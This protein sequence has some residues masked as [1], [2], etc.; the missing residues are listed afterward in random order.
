PVV[1][2]RAYTNEIRL[3]RTRF[4]DGK[5]VSPGWTAA[6]SW[7]VELCR[8]RGYNTVTN[9]SFGGYTHAM[10]GSGWEAPS[11]RQWTGPGKPGHII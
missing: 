11:L 6:Y 3:R 7:A 5:V 10:D 9:C 2:V 1:L 8:E 4:Q